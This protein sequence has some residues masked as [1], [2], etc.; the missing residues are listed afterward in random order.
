MMIRSLRST[1]YALNCSP[2]KP[3]PVTPAQAGSMYL[4]SVPGPGERERR[5]RQDVEV[6]QHRPVLDVVKVM[7]DARLNLLLAVGLAAPAVDLRP[8]GDAG[9]DAVAREIAVHRLVVEA[10]DRLGV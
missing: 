6:E 9:L 10:I 5:H 1:R 7:L 2:R 8:A 3:D 4:V